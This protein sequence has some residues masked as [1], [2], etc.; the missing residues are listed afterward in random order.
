[1]TLAVALGNI[2]IWSGMYM[3]ILDLLIYVWPKTLTFRVNNEK[4]GATLPHGHESCGTLWR[5]GSGPT[6]HCSVDELYPP[7]ARA[8]APRTVFLIWHMIIY[9]YGT[10]SSDKLHCS[11]ASR[12]RNA[13]ARPVL[14]R[15]GGPVCVWQGLFRIAVQMYLNVYVSPVIVQVRDQWR[16]KAPGRMELCV[17]SRQLANHLPLFNHVITN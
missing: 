3:F 7:H 5:F 2:S 4:Q 16:L 13:R 14:A 6:W 15:A 8:Q 11:V 1:M 17:C 12:T 10:T 9:K